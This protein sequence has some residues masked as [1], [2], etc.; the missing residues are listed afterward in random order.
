M[1]RAIRVRQGQLVFPGRRDPPACPVPSVISG[2]RGLRARRGHL[3]VQAA[4]GLPAPLGSPARW[5]RWEVPDHLGREAIL[6]RLGLEDPGDVPAHLVCWERPA[7][8]VLQVPPAPAGPQAPQA[9]RGTQAPSAYR[10]HVEVPELEGYR[11]LLDRPVPTDFQEFEE[12]LEQ[13]EHREW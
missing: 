13:V 10:D 2:L 5:V 8:P 7:I 1:V 6:A 3:V 12:A 4:A 9:P 11:E